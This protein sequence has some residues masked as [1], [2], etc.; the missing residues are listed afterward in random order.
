MRRSLPADADPTELLASPVW[1]RTVPGGAAACGCHAGSSPARRAQP[2][3]YAV[4]SHT[5]APN[6]APGHHGRALTVS[7]PLRETALRWPSRFA[8]DTA[9]VPTPTSLRCGAA[10][11]SARTRRPR[12]QDPLPQHA[13]PPSRRVDVGGD[14]RHGP[15]PLGGR[16][17]AR[18]PPSRARHLRSRSRR[19]VGSGRPDLR[20]LVPLGGAPAGREAAWIAV[21]GRLGSTA[22]QASTPTGRRTLSR[23]L[24]GSARAV[25][26]PS[27]AACADV[28]SPASQLSSPGHI[29]SPSGTLLSSAEKSIWHSARAQSA[30]FSS[31]HSSL[32][33]SSTSTVSTVMAS[34]S[35][36]SA[37]SRA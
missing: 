1:A 22:A 30:L 37:S 4:R 32:S 19:R 26:A 15:R 5:A 21:L 7:R 8:A 31:P 2:S 18:R 13:P 29:C 6:A 12:T 28:G 10:P 27:R 14:V 16:S 17:H 24:G 23:D 33:R 35:S 3:Q 9:A 25:A 11:V 34:S 36:C 20:Y